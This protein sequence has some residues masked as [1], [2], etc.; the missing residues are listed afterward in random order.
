MTQ[1]EN[2]RKLLPGEYQWSDDDRPSSDIIAAR[3]RAKYYGARYLI[4]LPFL[5]HAL[6]PMLHQSATTGQLSQSL[7]AQSAERLQQAPL[8]ESQT[9]GYIGSRASV[10]P[11][12]VDPNIMGA[13]EIC[14]KA[15]IQS[16]V[17]FDGVCKRPIFT[18]IFGIAHAYVLPPESISL[19]IGTDRLQTI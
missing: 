6:H 9:R 17:T 3:M 2:W 8:V 4:H 16:T 13:A 12:E 11:E 1:L 18:N 15:A 7:T 5:H 14:V 19:A 10:K